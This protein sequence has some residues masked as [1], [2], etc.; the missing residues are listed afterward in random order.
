MIEKAV[1]VAGVLEGEDGGVDEGVEAGDIL[2]KRFRKVEIHV[3]GCKGS[4]AVSAVG[5]DP[6]WVGGRLECH[7]EYFTRP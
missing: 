6:W 4:G 2:Y 7:R 5:V 1:V 3:C